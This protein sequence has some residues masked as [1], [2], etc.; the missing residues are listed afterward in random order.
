MRTLLAAVAL[1]AIASLLVTDLAAAQQ[2][3]I[4]PPGYDVNLFHQ[5]PGGTLPTGIDVDAA[6][7]VY[8]CTYGGVVKILEDTD[9]DGAAEIATTFWDGSAHV[10]PPCVGVLL[11]PGAVLVAHNGSITRL[12]DTNGDDVADVVTDIVTGL[13]TALH[14]NNQMFTDGTYVYF[15][16]GSLTD[17]DVDPDP[18]SATLMRMDPDGSN[19]V[20]GAIGLRNVFDGVVHPAQ[21]D[22]FVGD[23][24]PNFVPGNPSPPDEVNLVTAG[25]DYGHP[26]NWGTPPTGATTT[27]PVALLPAHASPCGMAVNPNTAISGHRN[28]IIMSIF[29]NVAG[30]IARLPTHYGV[31]SGKVGMWYEPW[32]N[33][34]FAPIDVA[35]LPDGTL[36]L[37]DYAGSRLWRVAPEGEV[38]VTVESPPAIGTT[39]NI[40]I[41][42]P[43]FANET[44]YISASHGLAAAP[45]TFGAANIYIDLTSALWTLSTTPGNPF[46][47]FP[48]PGTL[49]PTG[50]ATAQI[51]V[52]NDPALVGFQCDIQSLVV[53]Q[54]P[55]AIATASSPAVRL[56]VIHPW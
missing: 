29:T 24:G 39:C 40:T 26:S 49:D 3:V 30:S 16:L 7:R 14:Q 43:G 20:I 55:G 37:L 36:L 2:P 53:A 27:A 17:H 21:G 18:R 47:Q 11:V 13:P 45:I 33:S 10:T 46:F 28:E 34:M 50:S 6:G 15:G 1:A 22:I 56:Y 31:I 9:G 38:V 12:E 52:P 51:F 48:H 23:N 25:G 41:S 5:E 35:F 42:S 19:Q 8:Q 44:V 4:L 54:G 32:A